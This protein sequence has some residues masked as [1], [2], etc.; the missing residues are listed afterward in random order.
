[1]KKICD[2][3]KFSAQ[4]IPQL[5]SKRNKTWQTTSAPNCLAKLK[6]WWPWDVRC[7]REGRW[8]LPIL[9]KV[10]MSCAT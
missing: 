5:R 9:K 1:V 2:F 10:R 7:E 8:N 3:S 4:Y 6:I